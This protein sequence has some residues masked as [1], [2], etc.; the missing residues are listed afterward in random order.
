[1]DWGSQAD[2]GAAA[3]EQFLAPAMFEP[4]AERLVERANVGPGLRVLDLACGTGVVS[5]AAARRGGATASVT[6]VDL[7]EPTLAVARSHAPEEG[8]AEIEYL[9][10]DASVL[11]FEDERFDIVLCQQG[12][13]FF[14]DRAGA[15][16]EMRRVSKTGATLAVAT[17]KNIE[18]SPFIAIADALGAHV[19]AE[20]GAMMHSPFGLSDGSELARA[21]VAAGFVDVLVEDETIECTWA[22][23]PDFAELAIEAGPIGPRFAAAD[24][25]ARRL[26][27]AEVA[28]RLTPNATADGR[29]RMA[30][31]SN[32][33]LARA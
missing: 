1:M 4:F 12:L 18:R 32:V 21:I 28:E 16:A 33:A 7:G 24:G 10:A 27:I 5:R 3:Y 6:G 17:W 23:H 29:L 31:H 2:S 25:A 22:S 13:Q 30:M 14:P 26:V 9:Q 11:P 20:A 15:L 8:A 19:S